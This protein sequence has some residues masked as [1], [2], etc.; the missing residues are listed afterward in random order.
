MAARVDDDALVR[1]SILTTAAWLDLGAPLDSSSDAMRLDRNPGQIEI[2]DQ[3]LS[4]AIRRLVEVTLLGSRLVDAPLYRLTGTSFE[5]RRVAGSFGLTTFAQYALTMDLLEGELLDAICAGWHVGHPE[6]LPLRNSL[7]PDISAV[8]DFSQRLC[9]G[10]AL[11]LT[12][13]AR[14]SRGS[15]RAADD[16]VVL[17]QERSGSVLNASGRLA[18]IPKSFHGPLADFEGETRI[19][20]T[21]RRELEEELFGREDVDSTIGGSHAAADPMHP[22]RLSEPMRWLLAKSESGAWDL[23]CT[24]VGLN[25]VSGNFEFACL[26]AVHDPEFW[27]RFGGN[28]TANWEAA[29]LR[30]YSSRDRGGL[31]GLAE[32][33]AWSNE[34]A[35]ALMQGFR[36]LCEIG[37]AALLDMP[38]IEHGVDL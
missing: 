6:A 10:G 4:A 37:D 35:F 2:G 36:R 24:G 15:T 26:F 38:R 16:Y 5:P 34:G 31:C 23:E 29:G 30:Q 22:S 19:G 14:P 33:R 32:D 20:A 13:I 1:T 17:I 3:V 11:A 9:C 21:V 7:L 25:L 8:L 27:G 18:V 28:I 12:A